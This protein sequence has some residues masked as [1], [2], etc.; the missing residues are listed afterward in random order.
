[1]VLRPPGDADLRFIV[2]VRNDGGP[3]SKEFIEETKAKLAASQLPRHENFRISRVAIEFDLYEDDPG[4]IEKD[5]KTVSAALG[6]VLS[7]RD[8]GADEGARSLG[9]IIS[10]SKEMYAEERFWEVHEELE[11]IWR[12]L[13]RGDPEKEVLQGLIL[14]A[15][16]Y[17]HKQKGEEAVALSVLH[18]ARLRLVSFG[19]AAYHGIDIVSLIKS[20]TRVEEAGLVTYVKL[21]SAA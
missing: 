19:G 20:L 13:K 15:A 11:S 5:V 3:A 21:P 14:L 18:R 1:M 16:A 7:V 8:L 12:G 10:L 4:A 2:R 9:Q 17:V 6:L